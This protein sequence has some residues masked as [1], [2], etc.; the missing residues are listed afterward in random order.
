MNF[1]YC[2]KQCPIGKIASSTFLKLNES[3]IQGAII[4]SV[5]TDNCFETCPYKTK[6]R[7]DMEVIKDENN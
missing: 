1:E 6:L 3:A 2:L 4:F 5:F 7:V